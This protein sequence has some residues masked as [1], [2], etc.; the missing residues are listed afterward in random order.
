MNAVRPAILVTGVSGNL[1]SRLV[2]LLSEA[3]DVIGVDIRPPQQCKVTRFEAVDLGKEPSCEQLVR[4]LRETRASAVI[5][6]AFV[7]DAHRAGVFDLDRMWRINV[8]G[9]ARVMEA[10]AEVNRLYGGITKFICASSAAA[11]GPETPPCVNED[12]PLAAHTLASAIH[13]READFVVRYRADTMGA[14]STYLLRTPVI[15]GASVQ[16]YLVGA[17]RGV[18]L[19][20]GTWGQRLRR[21]SKRLPFVTPLGKQNGDKL[22]QFVHVDDIA[23]LIAHI[24][25]REKAD[26]P[27]TVL[28]ASG[29]GEPIT[30]SQAA[31]IANVRLVRAPRWF[32]R[33]LLRLMWK[34]EISTIPAEALPYLLG[35][36]T[37]DTTR[38]K[39]FLGSDYQRVIKYS[40]SEALADTFNVAPAPPEESL[41]STTP[42]T[43]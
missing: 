40:V 43:S 24:I 42:A 7:V 23:R 2:P 33:L 32:A 30:F 27:L 36:C 25:V 38:L 29:R 28:N 6:L 18:P 4:L 19:G 35:S 11:Y 16:N 20:T 21:R 41:V 5:H 37:V 9:T 17:L 10:V 15:T 22:L 3:H 13:Q 26:S 8:P 31:E 1:G 12:S 39:R 34:M 14:C